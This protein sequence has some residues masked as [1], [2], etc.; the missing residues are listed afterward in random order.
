MYLIYNFYMQYSNDA[1]VMNKTD[2]HLM[3][4]DSLNVVSRSVW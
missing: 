1:A 4:T 3:H 2:W